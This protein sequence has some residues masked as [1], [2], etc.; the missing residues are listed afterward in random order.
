MSSSIFREK[1]MEKMKSPENLDDYIRVTNPGLWL[2][3]IAIGVLLVGFFLWGALGTIETK[4]TVGATVVE[5]QAICQ[6]DADLIRGI[7]KRLN[8]GEEIV[9]EMNG[10]KGVITGIDKTNWLIYGEIDGDDG[11]GTAFIYE[12]IRPMSLLFD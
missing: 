2:I 1:S 8:G 10:S 9:F 6:G 5:G 3:L 7:E 12:S 11:S 4:T